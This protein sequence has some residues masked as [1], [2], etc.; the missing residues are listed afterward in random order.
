VLVAV[1]DAAGESVI[2]EVGT[3]VAASITGSSTAA[4]ETCF[5]QETTIKDKR[6]KVKVQ[7]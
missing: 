4:G 7:K 2:L 1:A 5:V 6:I 3:P